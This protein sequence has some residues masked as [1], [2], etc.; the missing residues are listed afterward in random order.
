MRLCSHGDAILRF[1]GLFAFSHGS[2]WNQQPF[3]WHMALCSW[4]QR[5]YVARRNFNT[6]EKDT[7]KQWQGVGF[8]TKLSGLDVTIDTY[9]CRSGV[10]LS[11][12]GD[13]F[14]GSGSNF[15]KTTFWVQLGVLSCAV[16]A[17]VWCVWLWMESW[18]ECR[19]SILD[20]EMKVEC[21][22]T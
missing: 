2:N 21:F 8:W 10:E 15:W 5:F 17:L 18:R 22:L 9:F 1:I 4:W 11:K 7:K 19:F 14:S 12:T 20:G 16:G 6:Q 13:S 3:I